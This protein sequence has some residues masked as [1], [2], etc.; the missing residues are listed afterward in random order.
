MTGPA[1]GRDKVAAIILAA[2]ES[3]RMGQLKQLLPW[4]GTT[5]LAWQVG[6]MRLAGAEE[7]V[8]VLGHEAQAIRQQ[9]GDL[10]A[11]VIVNEGYTEGRAS[12]LRA[13]AEALPDDTG[14]VLILSV[15]QPR[16]AAIAR[17]LIERWQETGAPL[18]LPGFGERRGH[19]VLVDGSLLDELRNVT[20]AELGLR[21]VTERHGPEAE[22]VP[23][24]NMNLNVDLN[25][26]ADYT[27]AY[28][29]FDHLNW[30]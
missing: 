14:A 20:E 2:G 9:A 22:I 29:M 19:P 28:V 25:T 7:V 12:S 16:P 3:S 18:V 26:P 8:V 30:Q 5:L 17:A 24:E 27:T 21:A 15:D 10:P 1:G 4:A 23:I 6:Q 13:G 11:R